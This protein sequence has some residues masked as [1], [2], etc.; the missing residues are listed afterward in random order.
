MNGPAS[1][2]P[3]GDGRHHLTC[4]ARI[5][6][7]RSVNGAEG[8]RYQVRTTVAGRVR[9]TGGAW[10]DAGERRERRLRGLSHERLCRRCQDSPIT[11]HP[12]THGHRAWVAL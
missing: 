10:K 12:C 4:D 9:S 8:R 7:T 2:P 6:K 5:W 1:T 11:G 3:P